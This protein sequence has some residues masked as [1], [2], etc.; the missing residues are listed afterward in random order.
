[1]ENYYDF[2]KAH[3]E[4]F[5]QFSC[6][7]LLFLIIDCPPDFTKGEDWSQHN[8]FLH[9]LSGEKRLFS[10]ERSW[11]VKEGA[12]VFMKKGAFGLEKIGN[13][14]FCVLLF[15]VPDK[16]IRTF[17]R[18]NISFIQRVDNPGLSKDQVLPVQKTEVMSAFY[19]SVLPYF[20]AGTQPAENLLEL[21]FKE[22]LLNIITTGSNRELTAYF[23]KLAQEGMDDLQD[24]MDNNCLY[25]LQLHEYARLCHRSLS[26]FKRDFQA[27]YGIPPGRWLLEKRLEVARDLLL[28]TDK[29]VLDVVI[30]SGFKNN[31]HF[32]RVFKKHFGVQPLRFRKGLAPVTA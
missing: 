29:P 3:P 16:Y 8:C 13:H 27:V 24:I 21:K 11:F 9:V 6:K 10:R 12:T 31:A 1:M 5:R 18:E 17:I 23:Y 4:E 14:P 20:S 2:V 28:N 22:L 7:E 15:Y 26:S 30:E 19:D 25:N 32:D